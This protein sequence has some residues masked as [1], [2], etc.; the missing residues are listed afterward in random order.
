MLILCLFMLIYV[1]IKDRH[2]H[3][4][5]SSEPHKIY[6]MMKTFYSMYRTYYSGTQNILVYDELLWCKMREKQN[7]YEVFFF[8]F[9]FLFRKLMRWKNLT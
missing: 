8:P 7:I 5:Y 6:T 2:T 3:Q 4:K 1:K 9:Y